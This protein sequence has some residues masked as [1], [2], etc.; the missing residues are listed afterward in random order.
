MFSLSQF[1]ALRYF[2]EG[3]VW[4]LPQL[5]GGLPCLILWI[6]QGVLVLKPKIR[7]RSR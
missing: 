1:G 5:R 3:K 6:L 2:G 4:G 7:E